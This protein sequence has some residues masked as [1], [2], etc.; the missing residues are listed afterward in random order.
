MSDQDFIIAHIGC[1]YAHMAQGACTGTVGLGEW[2]SRFC[3][4]LLANAAIHEVAKWRGTDTDDPATM[5][6]RGP[7][8]FPSL[9]TR[10]L[11]LFAAASSPEEAATAVRIAER[12]QNFRH[13]L[14]MADRER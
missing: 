6:N 7:N 13:E 10:L 5:P 14:A 2:H 9:S 8:Q 1:V 12:S 4:L 11:T 3:H